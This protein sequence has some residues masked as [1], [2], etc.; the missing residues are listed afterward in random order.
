MSFVVLQIILCSFYSTNTEH[1]IYQT[2]C[3]VLRVKGEI[4][5]VWVLSQALISFGPQP[6]SRWCLGGR[7]RWL[8]GRTEV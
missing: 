5:W 2:A 3:Q 4:T 7:R 8:L 6:F 1:I